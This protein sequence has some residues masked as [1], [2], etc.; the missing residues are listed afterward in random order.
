MSDVEGGTIW[1]SKASLLVCFSTGSIGW[2][3]ICDGCFG[4]KEKYTSVNPSCLECMLCSVKDFWCHARVEWR[5]VEWR[6][7]ARCGVSECGHY[8]AMDQWRWASESR[9]VGG[10]W[11]SE[12]GW[13]SEWR[14][15]G[16]EWVSEGWWVSEDEWAKV[17]KCVS[18]RGKVGGGVSGHILENWTI[19]QENKL[20]LQPLGYH[21]PSYKLC[22]NSCDDSEISDTH[23]TRW[24]KWEN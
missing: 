22:N 5:G 4:G 23:N 20:I 11:M 16:R 13:A 14:M 19:S 17:G 21:G 2:F 7:V 10:G 3:S 1:L 18:E 24:R 8:W 9:M 12:W 15:T 6:G